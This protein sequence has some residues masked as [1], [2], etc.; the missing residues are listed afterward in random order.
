MGG[1]LLVLVPGLILVGALGVAVTGVIFFGVGEGHIAR[2]FALSLLEL[3][4]LAVGIVAMTRVM[5][6]R[7]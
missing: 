3:A 1:S 7:A 6:A 5:D 2:A 4:V